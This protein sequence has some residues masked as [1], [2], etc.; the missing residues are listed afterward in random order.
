MRKDRRPDLLSHLATAA[1]A[2]TATHVLVPVTPRQQ[3][4]PRL[5]AVRST[6]VVLDLTARLT[7]ARV[8]LRGPEQALLDDWCRLLRPMAVLLPSVPATVPTLPT[9][10][11]IWLLTAAGEPCPPW[12]EPVWDAARG[13]LPREGTRA[14]AAVLWR[15]AD[16]LPYFDET[17]HGDLLRQVR[18][19]YPRAV[20][21]LP[22]DQTPFQ[23]R[24]GRQALL[25]REVDA[26]IPLSSAS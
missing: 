23:L 19:M 14:P 20:A 7:R 3:L 9:P 17:A 10:A 1:G 15:T 11:A 4:P 24:T 12:A 22:P 18:M 5:P 16:G 26:T 2:T 25:V 6:H 21:L 8:S 13:T